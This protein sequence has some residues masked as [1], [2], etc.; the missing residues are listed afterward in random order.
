[1]STLRELQRKTYRAI[2][3][4]H[5]ARLRWSLVRDRIPVKTRVQVYA[6]N[7]QETTRKTLATSYPVVE[8]LVG[9]L[10]FRN[11]S[12]T[13]VARYPS[14]SGDLALFG[15]RFSTLL[16]DFYRDTE[17]AYLSS[18]ASLEW[19]CVESGEAPD[20][21]P[22]EET[23]L[24]EIVKG[25]SAELRL[26]IHPAIRLVSEPYCIFTIWRA[27]QQ[28]TFSE[29]DLGAPGENVLVYRKDG[30]VLLRPIDTPTFAFLAHLRSD[31]SVLAAQLA[32]AAITNNFDPAVP[33]RDIYAEGLLV[34][35]SR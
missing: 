26:D 25:D 10:C 32:A 3:Q 23:S 35:F 18:V 20:A 31:G 17:F 14:S 7:L 22:I 6:N 29:I 11:L 21:E 1:M 28:E 8:A 5:S 12:R 9:A 15:R 13:Y 30:R 34:G 24:E 2:A 19:A 33:L 16:D 27:H 4:N